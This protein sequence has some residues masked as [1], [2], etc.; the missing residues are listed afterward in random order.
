M[1]SARAF[2]SNRVEAYLAG[3]TA[4]TRI[5]KMG[6]SDRVCPCSCGGTNNVTSKPGKLSRRDEIENRQK[7]SQR[8][9]P[10]L[11]RGFFSSNC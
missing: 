3:I 10:L 4:V 5:E 2:P 11:K 6:H 7:A 9:K 1:I 8:K